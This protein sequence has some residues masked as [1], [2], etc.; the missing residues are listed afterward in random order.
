MI[1]YYY[2]LASLLF[3]STT[4]S[5]VTLAKDTKEKK[6]V[7]EQEILKSMGSTA[8]QGLILLSYFQFL[9][10][11]IAP[12]DSDSSLG[13]TFDFGLKGFCAVFGY[14]VMKLTELLMGYIVQKSKFVV[15][16]TQEA[17]SIH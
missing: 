15:T 17:L 16:R 2:F 5:F 11:K 3:L 4:I 14:K 1:K 13:K 7:T 12:T 9:D 8:I 6:I 10:N